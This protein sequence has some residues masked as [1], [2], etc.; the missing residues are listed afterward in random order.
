MY[1]TAVCAAISRHILA[2]AVCHE[3]H[4]I[5]GYKGAQKIFHCFTLTRIAENLV[6][7]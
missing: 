3:K 5:Q 2:C 6:M 1:V 7:P 4:Q